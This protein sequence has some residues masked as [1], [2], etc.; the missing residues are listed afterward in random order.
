MALPP[1]RAVHAACRLG[2]QLG[3]SAGGHGLSYK[4]MLPMA[5]EF[6]GGMFQDEKED[7]ADLIRTRAGLGRYGV[8]SS[9]FYWS[10]GSS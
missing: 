3:L 1:W 4:W 2:T 6:Q 10:K 8:T 9:T 5:A 7:N